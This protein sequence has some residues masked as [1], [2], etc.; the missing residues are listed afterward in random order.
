MLLRHQPFFQRAVRDCVSSA[1]N[2]TWR[3]G[4]RA[5]VE[6]AERIVAFAGYQKDHRDL[7]GTALIN[8]LYVQT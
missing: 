3:G 2:T 7:E 4:G 5:E 1:K 8:T 6:L